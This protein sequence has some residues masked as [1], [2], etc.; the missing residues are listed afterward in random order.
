MNQEIRFCTCPD[1]ARIAYALSGRGPPLVMSG[2]WLNHLEYQWHNLAWR[3][4]L[5]HFSREYTLLRYDLRGTGLSD[6]SFNN[7]SA[8]TWARDFG[9]VVDAAGYERFPLLGI[10]Q[11]GPIAINYAARHPERVSHLLLYGTYARGNFMR[12][13]RP[14][15]KPGAQMFIDMARLGWGTENPE[16]M[17]VWA[18]VF[19]LQ[20]GIEHQRTWMELQSRS[21]SPENAAL[22]FE[23]AFRTDVQEAAR[24]VQCPTL[25]VH[26]NKDKAAH[27]EEGRRLAGL[28]PNARFVELDSPNHMLLPDE[29]AWARLVDEARAFLRTPGAHDGIEDKLDAL[30]EREHQVL[31]GIARGLDNAEIA[32]ELALSEKTVRNHVTRV[33]DKIGVAHRYQAIVLA[34]EAGLAGG[35]RRSS[36]P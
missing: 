8:E 16:F 5:E 1:G 15:E 31:E 17:Q 26:A 13:E 9:S 6:R 25:V 18:T 11:G 35:R 19:Q 10:C 14:R 7:V 21:V 23:A 34:R 20:G 30:T 4:W 27:V 33:F 2:T 12:P 22:F 29:P 3:P 28:I 24:R 32:A 36:T